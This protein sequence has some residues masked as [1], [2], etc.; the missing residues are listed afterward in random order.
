MEMREPRV[1]EVGYLMLPN[2][3]QDDA[4]N[5]LSEIKAKIAELGAEHI[6]E[7]E[8]QLI[9]LA[10]TMM[11]VLE[12]KNAFYDT[13]Y[14]GWIKFA[15][16][17]ELIAEIEALFERR[18]DILRHLVTKTVREDTMINAKP[19]AS[20]SQHEMA[21]PDSHKLTMDESDDTDEESDEEVDEAEL[22]DK[23]DEM[24]SEEDEA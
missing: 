6:S 2:K 12:N 5:T 21:T 18:Q 7:G 13:A 17:P 16:N 22:D 14:F 11:K 3:T 19:L 9:D 4:I 8:P 23:L 20:A 1:Y 15:L 10:Y 24:T